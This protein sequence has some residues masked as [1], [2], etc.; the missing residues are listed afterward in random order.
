M[1]LNIR[2]LRIAAALTVLAASRTDAQSGSVS[3]TIAGGPHAGKYELTRGQCDA[4]NGQIISMFTP[5]LAGVAEGPK[6]P[7]SIE[8]YTEPGKGKTDGFAVNVDFRSPSGPRVVYEIYAIPPELQAPGRTKPPSGQGSV[9]IEQKAEGTRA[10]F[11]GQTKD[12][13]GMEG[14]V[15]CVKKE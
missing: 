9:K 2:T 5:K 3:V 6:T 8:V 15:N 1:S 4:L 11:R 13:I 14:S 12:G 10:T 7:E